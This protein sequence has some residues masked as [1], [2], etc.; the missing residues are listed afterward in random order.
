MLG[1]LLRRFANDRHIQVP[2]DYISD[3]SERHA[4]F[5]DAMIPGSRGT[6]LKHEPVKMSSIEPMHRGPAVEPI[7]YLDRNALL[8]CNADENRNE[9]MITIAMDRWRKA[10]H[11]HAHTTRCHRKSGLFRDT[12]NCRT[13]RRRSFFG[14]EAAWRK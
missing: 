5:G 9:A 7:A 13:G 6:L 4:L 11:R 2:A 8:T 12:G 1:C 3:V 14:N 10:H